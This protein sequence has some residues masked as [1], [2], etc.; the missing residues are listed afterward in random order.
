[1]YLGDFKEDGD[2]FFKFTT[3][4]FSTGATH[5]L[6]EP[7]LSVYIDEA[8][9]T[10]KTTTETYFDIDADFDSKT[11]LNNVRIDLSGDAFFATGADYAVVITTGT[12]DSVSV[13]WR[14]GPLR[15]T[16]PPTT[17]RKCSP[18]NPTTSSAGSRH[19]RLS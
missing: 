3:R 17:C 6:S 5:T 2:V 10:E 14:S 1:M 9:T 7:E 15:P 16:A 13:K 8:T 19:T 11:G 12:V 4:R 18:S